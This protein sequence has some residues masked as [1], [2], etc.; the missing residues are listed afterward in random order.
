MTGGMN[1]DWRKATSWNSVVISISNMC[2]IIIDNDN[3]LQSNGVSS[4]LLYIMYSN[5]TSF[6]RFE[7]KPVVKK[8]LIYDRL[9]L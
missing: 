5:M 6:K 1:E 2:F 4:C 8:I 7:S 3:E 9:N